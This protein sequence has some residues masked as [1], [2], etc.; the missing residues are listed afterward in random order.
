MPVL[1]LRARK[2]TAPFHMTFTHLTAC[3]AHKQAATVDSFLSPE[4][5]DK[6]ARVLREAGK[7][8]PVRKLTALQWRKATGEPP[9]IGMPSEPALVMATEGIGEASEPRDADP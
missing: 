6:L 7:P 5:F 9:A 3:D 8:I 2:E 4:G 1:A